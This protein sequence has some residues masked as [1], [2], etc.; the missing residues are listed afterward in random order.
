MNSLKLPYKFDATIMKNEVAQFSKEDFRDIYN[1]SVALN[2]LW[3]KDFIVPISQPGEQVVFG[4]NEALKKC[5]CLLSI[6]KTFK[7]QVDTFRIHSL[8]PGAQ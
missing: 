1:P 4:P 5:P 8:D 2:S 7:C 3:L 6:F